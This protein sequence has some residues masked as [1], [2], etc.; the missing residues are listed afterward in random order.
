MT[1]SIKKQSKSHKRIHLST[2]QNLRVY[3]RNW[4]KESIIAWILAHGGCC[5]KPD[6]NKFQRLFRKGQERVDQ[7]TDIVRVLKY[8]KKL[9]IICE[10]NVEHHL[11]LK[12]IHHKKNILAIDTD[13]AEYESDQASHDDQKI[14]FLG[15]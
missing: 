8:L 4:Y 12:A 15:G 14:N 11:H 10:E 9:R 7:E 2:C 6:E 1:A 13:T 5:Q 3:V